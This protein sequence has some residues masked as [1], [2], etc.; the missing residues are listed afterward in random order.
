M[1]ALLVAS[2]LC[3]LARGDE[4]VPRGGT[5]PLVEYSQ[6]RQKTRAGRYP[7]GTRLL[8]TRNVLLSASPDERSETATVRL[9]GVLW[10]DPEYPR[11]VRVIGS[12]DALAR[13][14]AR[15]DRWYHVEQPLSRR[16]EHVEGWLFGG[17]VTPLA[18]ETR[19]PD[20]YAQ[21]ERLA[22]YID[23]DFQLVAERLDVT[24]WILPAPPR[25]FPIAA[26]DG[27]RGGSARAWRVAGRLRVE[28]RGAGCSTTSTFDL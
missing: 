18:F 9:H 2:L 22:V 3:G 24:P 13:R 28:L 20:S 16:E 25:R 10:A 12:T 15:V 11:F 17:D 27:G 23:D 1:R 8:V 21:T 26:C 19:A 7:A 14:G 5:A 6:L 4:S